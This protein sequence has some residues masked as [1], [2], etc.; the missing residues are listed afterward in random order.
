MMKPSATKSVVDRA[1]ENISVGLRVK[2]SD[3]ND[4]MCSILDDR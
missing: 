4:K 1:Q 2:P 3:L